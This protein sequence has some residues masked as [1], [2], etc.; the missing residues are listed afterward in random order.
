MII[1]S[2]LWD[3]AYKYFTKLIIKE[4]DLGRQWCL[5]GLIHILSFHYFEFCHQSSCVSY[6][7]QFKQ[8]NSIRRVV[9]G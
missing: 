4:D 1:P 9:S 8:G 5:F 2:L 3:F 7:G 6:M